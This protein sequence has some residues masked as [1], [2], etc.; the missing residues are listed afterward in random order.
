MTIKSLL[1]EAKKLSPD[2]R[3]IL[4]H[5]IIASVAEEYDNEPLSAE[6]KAELDRRITAFEQNPTRGSSWEEVDARLRAKLK[7]VRKK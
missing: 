4:A 1:K 2:K 5:E 7:K 3:E 6:L